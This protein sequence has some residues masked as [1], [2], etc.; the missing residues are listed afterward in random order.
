MK[1][2]L[3]IAAALGLALGT[4]ACE[5][6]SWDSTKRLFPPPEEAET[7]E[8]ADQADAVDD[9]EDDAEAADGAGTADHEP[10]ADDG[11][12]DAAV[13]PQ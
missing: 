10:F 1:A 5:R 12:R 4:G 6:H 9:A 13:L 7:A 11:E 3:L 8:P 2:F